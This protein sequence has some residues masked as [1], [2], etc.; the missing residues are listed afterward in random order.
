MMLKKISLGALTLAA[1]ATAVPQAAQAQGRYYPPGGPVA[2]PGYYGR[3]YARPYGYY[4]K[5]GGTTG[6][7]VGGAAGALLGYELGRRSGGFDGYGYRRNG[8]GTVGAILGGAA[9]ALLGREVDRSS[10]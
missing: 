8:N 2:G 10:C 3:N 4:R 9:G 1:A 5:C 7:I 6:A